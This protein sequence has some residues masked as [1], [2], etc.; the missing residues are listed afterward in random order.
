MCKQRVTCTDSAENCILW[1]KIESMLSSCAC[2][3]IGFVEDN[4]D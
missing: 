1:L 3:V 4:G 2:P